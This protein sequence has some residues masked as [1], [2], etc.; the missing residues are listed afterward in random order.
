MH[1]DGM[2]QPEFEAV[3]NA[4]EGNFDA[5]LEVGASV[6]LTIDGEPVVDLWGGAANSAGDPW[7]ENTIVNVYSST[8]TM[9]ALCVLMLADRGALDL[10]AGRAVLA[11][12]RRTARRT[13][14][15][16]T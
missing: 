7:V 2:C 12:V 16:G 9:A 4:F 10:D 11:R 3:R 14:S 5:G 6:A 8:K 13:C 1:A 15:C